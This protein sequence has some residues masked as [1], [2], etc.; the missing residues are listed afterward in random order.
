MAVDQQK[1]NRE[2]EEVL[3]NLVY[4][5]PF[6]TWNEEEEIVYLFE[7]CFQVFTIIIII[8]LGLLMNP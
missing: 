4:L 7:N 5:I 1:N 3:K 8:S 6:P 2:R